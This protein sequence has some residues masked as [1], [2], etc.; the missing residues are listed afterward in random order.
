M[1][2]DSA[3]RIV[4]TAGFEKD[5]VNVILLVIRVL[6]NG[7]VDVLRRKDGVDGHSQDLFLTL[8][9]GVGVV[10]GSGQKYRGVEMDVTLLPKI[11]LEVVVSK[12]PVEDV[13]EAA[14]RTLYTGKIGDGKIF[15]YSLDNVVKIR[16]GE[17]GAAALADVE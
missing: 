9:S 5:F 2:G 1:R 17:E 14:K 8:A 11:K 16:T 15:V 4:E 7:V 6:T 13:I 3:E 10:S 12:I